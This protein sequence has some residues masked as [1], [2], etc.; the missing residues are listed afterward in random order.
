[1]FSEYRKEYMREIAIKNILNSAKSL[2]NLAQTLSDNFEIVLDL[3][4]SSQGKIIFMGLGKSGYVAM[5]TAA[6]FNSVGFYAA[7]LH[8]TEALHG[9]LG[10]IQDNDI[11][12]SISQSGETEEMLLVLPYLRKKKIQHICLTGNPQSTLGQNADICLTSAVENEGT[13]IRNL[14][15]ASIITSMALLDALLACLIEKKN[16]C[17][18][19]FARLHP[20]GSLGKKLNTN[21][22]QLMLT[23]NLPTC[24]PDYTLDNLL[25]LIS[26]A[27]FGLA[28]VVGP[29]NKLQ[30][31]I[32]DGD[33]RRAFEKN[34]AKS[35][36]LLQAAE[37]MTVDPICIQSD[38][39]LAEAEQLMIRH[40]IT[41]VP[42]VNSGILLGLLT[43]NQINNG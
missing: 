35:N 17:Y 32:T 43:R 24:A 41:A 13:M 10:I 14:P 2:E 21:V 15:M 29:E 42:V 31:I 9:D 6:S 20:G 33:L 4:L 37:I 19:D 26:Q 18:E 3:L 12:C 11:L 28:L 36:Y 40:K 34:Q 25:K 23:Q 39:S 30:G 27:S 38:L 8:P 1:L 22:N 16:L 5:K 7:Y